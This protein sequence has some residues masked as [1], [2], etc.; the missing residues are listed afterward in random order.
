MKNLLILCISTLI[1][2]Y[3]C[4]NRS[5]SERQNGMPKDFTEFYQRF[6]QDSVYQMEHISFP[7]DGVP[8][9]SFRGEVPQNYKFQAADWK[10]HRAFEDSLIYYRSLEQV[11]NDIIEEEIGLDESGLMIYRRF[12]KLGSEWYLA[13]YM[14]PNFVQKK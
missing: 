2:G 6:H 13:Y 5:T 4:T 14:E 7:L 8:G 3:S 12:V 11:A 9:I 10:M 1:L